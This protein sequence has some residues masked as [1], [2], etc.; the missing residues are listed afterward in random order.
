MDLVKQFLEMEM[1]FTGLY[2]YLSEPVEKALGTVDAHKID[3]L[4][5][6]IPGMDGIPPEIAH[7]GLRSVGNFMSQMG[8]DWTRKIILTACEKISC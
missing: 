3:A 6:E 4:R 5:M 7:C 8:Y 2:L 1:G